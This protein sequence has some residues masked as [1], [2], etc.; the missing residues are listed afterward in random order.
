MANSEKEVVLTML[1]IEAVRRLTKNGK[2]PIHFTNPQLQRNL[3]ESL[4]VDYSK[5]DSDKF[6]LRL[7]KGEEVVLENEMAVSTE[8][9]AQ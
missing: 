9:E 1:L 8:G 3:M 7:V 5:S 6:V 2:N 4:E